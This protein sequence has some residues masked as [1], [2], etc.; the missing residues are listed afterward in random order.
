MIEHELVLLGLLNERPRHGY[1]IK[2]N[3]GEILS[4]FAGLDIKSVYYPLRILEHKGLVVKLPGREGKRPQRF[5]YRLTPKG[6]R[7]FRQLLSKSFL[8]F[9]RP[10]FSLDVSLYFL[11]HIA[12]PCARRRLRARV[13][14]LK[15]VAAGI[16]RLRDTLDSGTER[17]L[18][19]ILDHNLQMVGTESAF[20]VD[21]L[22]SFGKDIR[23]DHAEERHEKGSFI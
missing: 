22:A 16:R 4:L 9:R 23:T 3:I 11:D 15:R 14:I 6:R 1:E 5:V 12:V 8:D 13:T 20:L 19:R 10:Q 17:L 18:G 21:L 7:R 2:K